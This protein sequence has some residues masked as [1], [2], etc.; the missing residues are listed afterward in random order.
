MFDAEFDEVLARSL[1][2]TGEAGERR[3]GGHARRHRSSPRASVAA[4]A[5]HVRESGDRSAARPVEYVRRQDD[6]VEKRR[7]AGLLT[8]HIGR[9]RANR[10]L[11]PGRPTRAVC[12]AR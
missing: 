11:L 3:F 8:S 12:A 10:R 5:G 7:T 4:T 6:R 2:P 1:C 9:R